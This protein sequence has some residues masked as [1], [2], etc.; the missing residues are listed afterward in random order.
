MRAHRSPPEDLG[1]E[2]LST[3]DAGPATKT[4]GDDWIGVYNPRAIRPGITLEGNHMTV[5]SRALAGALASLILVAACGGSATQ[6]PGTTPAAEAT[7]APA[8]TEAPGPT[9][10]ATATQE[11]TETQ[12][13]PDVSL[14]P[15]A[16]ADLEAKLPTEVNG[17]KFERTSFDGESFPAGLPIGDTDMEGLLSENGKTVR[18]VKVAIA[19]ASDGA[20]A[21][22]FVMA[23]QVEGVPSDK[24]LAWAADTMGTGTD[25]TTVGGKEVYGAG[26][27]GMAAYVYVKDDIIFYVFGIGG[28]QIAESLLEKLP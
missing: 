15:G 16:A 7:Q 27:A 13:A 28:T 2:G 26:A 14:Q 22:T 17:V 6:A 24:M 20:S 11:P 18:D 23:L 8:V 25:R 1:K 21:G 19:T 12:E 4:Y 5:D 10:E 9:Q 3:G